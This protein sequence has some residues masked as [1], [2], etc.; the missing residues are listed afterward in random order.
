MET[1]RIVHR[2]VFEGLFDLRL[3][4]EG[5]FAAALARAGYDP[6]RPRESYPIEVW[7]ACLEVARTT[8][9]PEL[10][11]DEGLRWIGRHFAEGFSETLV[12]RVFAAATPLL[13]PDRVIT[14]LPRFLSSARD[15]VR[16]DVS[17]AGPHHWT[18][19]MIDRGG[20]GH[21]VAGVVERVLEHAHC[22]PTVRVTASDPEGF[23]LDVVWEHPSSRHR[24]IVQAS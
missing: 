12:G 3:R 17:C 20:T 18:L 24:P 4:P 9:Y 19:R 15:G 11:E 21:F 14:Q 16:L 23:T 1:Q 6:Y 22:T 7:R 8:L 2:R 5:A 13:G 10:P